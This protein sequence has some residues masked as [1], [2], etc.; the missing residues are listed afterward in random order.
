MT[1]SKR[2]SQN[3]LVAGFLAATLLSTSSAFAGEFFEA[4]GVAIKGFD[5]VAYFT[6]GKAV[7]GKKELSFDYMGS[8]FLFASAEHRDRFAKDPEVYAPQYRGYCA[9]GVTRG[10]KVKIEGDAFT[11]VDK[12]LYLNYDRAVQD[13]WRKDPKNEIAAADARWPTLVGK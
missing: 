9:Y 3:M 11:I 12:K 2:S 8:T 6:D 7:R 1:A 5:A 10:Y 4:D 13:D